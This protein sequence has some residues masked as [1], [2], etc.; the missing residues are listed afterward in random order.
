MKKIISTF[1]MIFAISCA[2]AL[3]AE[4][5]EI[6]V[7]ITVDPNNNSYVIAP[8]P[9]YYYYSGHR[10]YLEK[11]TDLSTTVMGY[12]SGV[13]GGAEIYCYPYP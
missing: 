7:P 5:V 13:A 11:R 10:C 3:F 12:Q 9:D 6:G 8:K 1:M 4:S 2:S